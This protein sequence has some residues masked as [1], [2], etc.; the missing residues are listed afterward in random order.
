MHWY[1]VSTVDAF[2]NY[3]NKINMLIIYIF[4]FN[5]NSTLYVYILFNAWLS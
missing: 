3:L 2:Y 4:L 1:A 5:D